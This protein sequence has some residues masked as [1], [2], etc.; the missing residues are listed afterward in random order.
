MADINMA[1]T[2]GERLKY[3]AVSGNNQTVITDIPTANKTV[4][5]S[6]TECKDG[7][8]N[9]YPVV[10]INTQIWMAENLKTSKY[11]DGTSLAT[12]TVGAAW[13]AFTSGAYCDYDNTPSNSTIYGKLYNWY[14]VDNNVATKVMSN[15]GRN[16]CPTGWHV[17]TDAEWTTL[18]DYLTNNGYGYQGSGNDIAK[19]MSTT[20]GWKTYLLSGTV[21]NNQSSNNK[22]GFTA[23]P[24]GYRFDS[25]EYFNI[26]DRSCWWSS[27]EFAA[28][29]G[30]FRYI[31]YSLLTLNSHSYGKLSGQSVRCLKD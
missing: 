14:A 12:A 23:L 28:G 6:F 7:D 18:T 9:Y 16:V 22:S 5:F 13:M 25:G 8:N 4:T 31:D 1:Y 15:G 2:A 30:R 10:Q 11:N 17:P 24:G 29:L 26:G 19:S 3:T 27:T 20:S 21:G